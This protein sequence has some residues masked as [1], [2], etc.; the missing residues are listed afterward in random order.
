[1]QWCDRLSHCPQLLTASPVR[2]HVPVLAVW[3]AVYPE[4]GTP[5]LNATTG[6]S[7]RRQHNWR[8]LRLSRVLKYLG[9][10][11]WLSLL[12]RRKVHPR[13]KS[14][15]PGAWWSEWKSQRA[16]LGPSYPAAT[17]HGS[18]QSTLAVL[19]SEL[20]GCLLRSTKLTDIYVI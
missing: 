11:S 1:M 9:G 15:G 6:S 20:W 7:A 14:F 5:P 8:L 4:G 13:H 2:L 17:C 3:P 19:S 10:V 18:K 16:E 12:S